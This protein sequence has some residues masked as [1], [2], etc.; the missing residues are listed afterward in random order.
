MARI[1]VVDDDPIVTDIIRRAL[2]RNDHEVETT[3]D[4]DMAMSALLESAFDVVI[5]DVQ[6]PR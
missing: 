6:M 2:V 4:S 3:N 5:L 1:F